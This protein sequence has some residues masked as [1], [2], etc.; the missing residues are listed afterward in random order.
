MAVTPS[1]G[2]RWMLPR[3]TFPALLRSIQSAGYRIVGPT[4]RDGAI[5]FGDIESV[6]DLP[7]GWTD[8][9]E[10]GTYR[11]ERRND[12]ALFGYNV[13][14]HSWKKYLFPPRE[15]MFTAHRTE[16]SFEV[17]T[18][19]HVGPPYAF[20]GVRGCELAAIRIQDRVFMGGQ[21][22]D[23]SYAARRKNAL[24]IAVQCGQS[25]ATCFCTSMGT[26]P[27][28]R[29]GFDLSITELIGDGTHEFVI[30]VGSGAGA[31][32]LAPLDLPSAVAAD[33][34][35]VSALLS[36]TKRTMGRKLDTVGI[37]DLLMGNLQ[38]PEWDDAGRRCL[39]CT[40]CTMACPTCFCHS[41]EEVPDLSAET[42]ERWRRWDSCFN[43]GFSE[44]HGGS[45]RTSPASRYRQWMTHK[46]ASW[47]DQFGSSGCVGCGRCVTWCPVAIDITVEAARIRAAPGK[48]PTKVVTP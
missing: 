21:V 20:L 1:L 24:V 37:R 18:E 30:E 15:K 23:P 43:L 34:E 11:L 5:V 3:A 7:K 33:S 39:S 31:N 26:G 36:E 48:G 6:D 17:T 41:T 27:E 42:V 38:H 29:E 16:T 19:E 35:R 22:V 47:Y 2:S 32:V 45:V 10:A 14:P 4:V 44:V 25:A 28:V 12:E 40:N 8:R 13:G 9:Q 46:L